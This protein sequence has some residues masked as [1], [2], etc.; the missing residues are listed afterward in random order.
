MRGADVVARRA[1]PPGFLRGGGFEVAFAGGLALTVG[2]LAD[3]GRDVEGRTDARGFTRE[4]EGADPDPRRGTTTL[5]PARVGVLVEGRLALPEDGRAVPRTP[6]VVGRRWSTGRSLLRAPGR[7]GTAVLGRTR[8]VPGAVTD[9]VDGRRVVPDSP[10]PVVEGVA[11][12]V[13]VLSHTC[14]RVGE[15]GDSLLR[16]WLGVRGLRGGTYSVLGDATEG[17]TYR[18][19]R[20]SG[21]WRVRTSGDHGSP[22]ARSLN[23]NR[24]TPRR[25]WAYT[26]RVPAYR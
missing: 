13:G 16:G 8:V 24:G 3:E 4:A 11:R 14:D 6:D 21:G 12:R 17:S 26:T 25:G 19:G 10:E 20:R 9:P 15:E 23:S 7:G 1:Q 5:V 18:A 22:S 2:R